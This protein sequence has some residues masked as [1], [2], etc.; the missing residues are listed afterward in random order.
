M[1]AF[2]KTAADTPL[3][4]YRVPGR[5]E[6]QGTL[7]VNQDEYATLVHQSLEVLAKRLPESQP[8]GLI[9]E[10]ASRD[11][12]VMATTEWLSQFGV[13]AAA[14]GEERINDLVPEPEQDGDGPATETFLRARDLEY[15]RE[16]DTLRNP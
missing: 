6:E 16:R 13:T 12:G 1:A 2:M 3:S 9:A 8:R 14:V 4:L 11:T 15:S 5:G 10:A 7:Y